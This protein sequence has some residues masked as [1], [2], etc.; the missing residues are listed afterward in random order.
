MSGEVKSFLMGLCAELEAYTDW[1]F[2]GNSMR[3][4]LLKSLMRL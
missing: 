1:H 2:D 4:G 3:N